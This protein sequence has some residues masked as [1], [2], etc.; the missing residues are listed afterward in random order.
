[1]NFGKTKQYIHT[2]KYYSALERSE[3][4]INT[5]V[6]MILEDIILNEIRPTKKDRYCMISIQ[7]APKIV[8]YIMTENTMWLPVAGIVQPKG[9]F[10][11]CMCM[12]VF[13]EP[14]NQSNKSNKSILIP[15]FQGEFSK[16]KKFF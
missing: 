6:W 8:K 13:Y 3:I 14:C 12:C 7:Q 16:F 1:M 10:V 15:K 2:L 11:L 5:I 4:L 9:C